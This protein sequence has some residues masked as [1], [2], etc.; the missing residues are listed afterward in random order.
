MEMWRLRQ[1]NKPPI[2]VAIIPSPPTAASKIAK[3]PKP[4]AA[5]QF[6]AQRIHDA[7]EDVQFQ[8]KMIIC[9]SLD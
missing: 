4:T 5:G 1:E 8:F 9:Q 3:S 7:D 2:Q 6:I